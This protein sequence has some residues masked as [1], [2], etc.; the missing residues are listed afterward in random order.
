MESYS[1]ERA[2]HDIGYLEGKTDCY[3]QI[4]ELI[5]IMRLTTNPNFYYSKRTLDELTRLIE[6]EVII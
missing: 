1:R 2:A 5:S 3:C 4:M 6:K